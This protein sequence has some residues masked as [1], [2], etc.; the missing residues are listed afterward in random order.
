MEPSPGV[1]GAYDRAVENLN[2]PI[3]G[4]E[5]LGQSSGRTWF[6]GGGCFFW[7]L[8][9]WLAIMWLFLKWSVIGGYVVVTI[10]LRLLA[11]IFTAIAVGILNGSEA[12]DRWHDR[13]RA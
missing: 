8:F 3:A 10:A 9:G 4:L 7:I 12:I 1:R 6:V 5:N 13:R 2:A 11:I